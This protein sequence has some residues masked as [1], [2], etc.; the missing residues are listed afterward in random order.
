MKAEL[1]PGDFHNKEDSRNQ[2]QGKF[3]HFCH[4]LEYDDPPSEIQDKGHQGCVANQG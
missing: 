3:N 4:G 2:N 1:C